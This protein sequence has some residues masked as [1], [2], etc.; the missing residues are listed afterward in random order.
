MEI[1]HTKSFDNTYKKLKN[2]HKEYNNFLKLLDIIENTKS[3]KELVN[4]PQCK[5]YKLERMKYDKNDY[6]SFNL[7]KNR[8]V[9]RLIIKP[10]DETSIELYLIMISYN[11]YED[12]NPRK[13]IY[14]E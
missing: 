4:L 7:S 8:G 3:F 6:Y 1:I 9:I 13:V 12:F 10:V 14:Y 11:H 2:H 5:M